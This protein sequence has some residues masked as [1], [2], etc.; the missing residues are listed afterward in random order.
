MQFSIGLLVALSTALL[1]F[2]ANADTCSEALDFATTAG[3]DNT[4]IETCWNFSISGKYVVASC[5]KEKGDVIDTRASCANIVDNDKNGPYALSN[6]DGDLSAGSECGGSVLTFAKTSSKCNSSP[7]SCSDYSIS[8]KYIKAVCKDEEQNPKNTKVACDKIFYN[9]MKQ[10]RYRLVNFDGSLLF[11]K[12][13][14]CQ[15]HLTL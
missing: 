4:A 12:E 2:A 10:S 7:A 11:D 3:P 14:G 8:G 5:K 13:G 1:A 9:G 6:Q 15:E